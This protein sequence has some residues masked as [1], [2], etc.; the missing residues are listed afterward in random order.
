MLKLLLFVLS[1]GALMPAVCVAQDAHTAHG[2]AG[3]LEFQND[4]VQVLRMRLGPREKIPMHALTERVIV[5]LTDAHLRVVKPDGK[6]LE[7]RHV[8][9]ETSWVAADQHEG[10]NL[11][12][13]TIEFI[14]V[15]PK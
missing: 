5:W 9:G 13:R 7:E 8:P 6:V 15:V 14:A 3:Q 11:G 4:R 1:A 2:P 10:E 12:D